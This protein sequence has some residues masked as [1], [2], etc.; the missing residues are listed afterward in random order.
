MAAA[1]FQ[2]QAD[3][4]FRK[5]LAIQRRAYKTNCCL[6]LFPV[7]V[8]GLLGGLQTFMDTLF[9]TDDGY[10]P[11]CKGCAGGGVRVRLSEDAVGG[12]ACSQ[13]CPLPAAQ[14]WPVALLLPAG[15][16]VDVLPDL[17]ALAGTGMKEPPPCVSPESCTAP[18]KFLVTGGNKSFAESLAANMFPPHA[19]P[20]L[21]ADISGLADY[22]LA[23]EG[24]SFGTNTYGAAFD[25]AGLYFLQRKCT[26][27]SILSF[28]V[29]YGPKMGIQGDCKLTH[30]N[31]YC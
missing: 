23:I 22:A 13:S 20:K 4:L 18:A 3:A 15:G 24:S 8:C 26:P 17:S 5:N 1:A 28:P 31:C 2:S 29:Q 16:A 27:N 10:K 14:R 19:S 30:T 12:L 25:M 9:N 6:I 11:D 7:L 21:T